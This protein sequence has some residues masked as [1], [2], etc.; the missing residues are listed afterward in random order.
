MKH[1]HYRDKSKANNSFNRVF[2]PT[3]RYMWAESEFW[4]FFSKKMNLFFLQF[5]V[6]LPWWQV[7]QDSCLQSA[8]SRLHRKPPGSAVSTADMLQ[9][10]QGSDPSRDWVSVRSALPLCWLQFKWEEYHLAQRLKQQIIKTRPE[11][12]K[13]CDTHSLALLASVLRSP[14][15][16]DFVYI[17]S[18]WTTTLLEQKEAISKAEVRSQ[19]TPEGLFWLNF[20]FI[21]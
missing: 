7:Q 13:V 2:S 21:Q 9:A 14:T 17:D 11:H 10:E 3:Y 5:L 16:F 19:W 12:H 1:N 8:S 20:I 6:N 18:K 15:S 4:P